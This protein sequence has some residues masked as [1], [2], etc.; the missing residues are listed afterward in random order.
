MKNNE[1]KPATASA[2]KRSSVGV[3]EKEPGRSGETPSRHKLDGRDADLGKQEGGVA[4]VDRALEILAAFEPT[5]K[6]LTLAELTQRTRFY[7]STIL[8]LS[9]SLIRHR[10]LQRLDDGVSVIHVS[11]RPSG[12]GWRPLLAGELAGRA[13]VQISSVERSRRHRKAC[14]YP[15]SPRP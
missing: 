5:D 1:R 2:R 4:A 15:V 12:D 9:Q 11:R 8:R 14:P 7:K 10:F 3:R 13:T 6:A